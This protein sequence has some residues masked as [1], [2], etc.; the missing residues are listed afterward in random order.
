[1]LKMD[2]F[3]K[4]SS[5]SASLES[6]AAGESRACANSLSSPPKDLPHARKE[7]IRHH[8]E[9]LRDAEVEGARYAKRAQPR[10]NLI[11]EENERPHEFQT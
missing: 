4:Y 11:R 9:N 10:S 8:V 3:V 1:M 7:T 5:N 2:E 6:E